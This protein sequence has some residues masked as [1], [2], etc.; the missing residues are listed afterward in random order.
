MCSAEKVGA[1]S[2]SSRA[3]ALGVKGSRQGTAS[4]P[5]LRRACPGPRKAAAP[6]RRVVSGFS[7]LIAEASPS[8]AAI[9][10]T[11]LSPVGAQH[12]APGTDTWQTSSDWTQGSGDQFLKFLPGTSLRVENDVT[13]SKQT[14]ATFLPGPRTA[15]CALR[16]ATASCPDPRRVYPEPRSACPGPR[17]A[18][19]PIRR[20]VSG[21]STLIAEAS[22]SVAAINRT[23]LSPVGAQHA[24]P[25]TDTGQTSSDWTQGS[26]DQFLK[27]LPG[28][29]LRVENDVTCSK[30]TI[31]TFLPGTRT[32]QC[33][34]RHATASCPD[35]R[36]VYPEPR[37]AAVPE[38]ELLNGLRQGDALG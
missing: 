3:V 14:L 2:S 11:P 32:A 33:A 18:A 6:I 16:H 1:V 12:A 22:P 13:C 37:S 20:V 4:C 19:A 10:R 27:F 28:T 36:R 26:G 24:A 34:L 23:P 5:E 7:T 35:P 17:K 9:N 30:Q 25:G 21:F 31:A 38:R 15:Q 8:V 29:S